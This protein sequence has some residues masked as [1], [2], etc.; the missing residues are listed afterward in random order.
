MTEKF[1]HVL[2]LLPGKVASKKARRSKTSSDAAVA[3]VDNPWLMP[4]TVATEPE[5]DKKG[6]GNV[7]SQKRVGQEA[8]VSVAVAADV[9]VSLEVRMKAAAEA[10]NAARKGGKDLV[11][12]AFAG[13]G[14]EEEDFQREKEE[15][16]RI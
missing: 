3:K 1:L 10:R 12:A 15:T 13:A 11:R 9:E 2:L 6:E 8:R 4:R 7:P 14:A 5:Q 16:V